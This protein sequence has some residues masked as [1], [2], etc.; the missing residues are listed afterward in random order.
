VQEAAGERLLLENRKEKYGDVFRAELRTFENGA[1]EELTPG[2]WKSLAPCNRQRLG[3]L[4]A[5]RGE[6]AP[7]L[8]PHSSLASFLE[9]VRALPALPVGGWSLFHVRLDKLESGT[10]QSMEMALQVASAMRT[11]PN[12][13]R[14]GAVLVLLETRDILRLCLSTLG[15]SDALLLTPARFKARPFNFP[16]ALD[17]VLAAA[18]LNILEVRMDDVLLDACCVD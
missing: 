1:L 5:L 6:M 14:G 17:P 13:G 4:A 18:A 10:P 11:K 15:R 9:G 12:G 3:Q 16:A 7:L 2:L 8:G